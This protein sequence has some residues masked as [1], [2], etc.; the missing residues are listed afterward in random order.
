MRW[1]GGDGRVESLAADLVVDASG[2]GTLTLDALK[3]MARALPAET[4]IGVDLN[5]GTAVY[6][7]PGDA[8][9]DW[10]G[11]FVFPAV[12]GAGGAILLP[13]EGKRWIVTIGTRHDEKAPADEAAVLAFAQRLRQPTLHDAIRRATPRGPVTR[14]GF[15]ESL[16]RHYER[17]G[18]FPP[19]LLPIGD[20]IGRRR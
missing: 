13:L 15:P 19:G 14:F 17:L 1:A 12:R 4:T 2:R 20:Y 11:L 6:D 16:F 9:A 3:S 7:I 5:Y 8:P 10:Q 18:D